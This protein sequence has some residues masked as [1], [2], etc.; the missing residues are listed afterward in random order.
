MRIGAAVVLVIAVLASTAHADDADHAKDMARQAFSMIDDSQDFAGASDLFLQAYDLTKNLPYL[1]NAAV[2]LRKAHLPQQAVITLRRYLVDAGDTIAPEMR[3]QIDGDIAE[4]TKES[5]RVTVT[6]AADSSDVSLDG[7]AAGAVSK[8]SPLVVLV[9]TEAGKDHVLRAHRDGWVDDEH[10]LGALSPGQVLDVSVEPKRPVT[11]GTL[12][13]TSAPDHAKLFVAGREYGPA[14]QTIELA[15]GSYEV[16]A[17]LD[18]YDDKS[19]QL[20]LEAGDS[21]DL[22]IRLQHTWWQRN[23]LWVYLGAGAVAAIGVGILVQPTIND[24]FKPD[25]GTII[26][27]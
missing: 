24:L 7:R 12:R 22:T 17:K 16:F 2:A 5:A 13:V 23:K 27:H 20:A 11:T 4:I 3:T 10:H 14:P 15:P 19:E 18:G 8:T 21:R 9:A 1:L 26:R 6:I 25:Y